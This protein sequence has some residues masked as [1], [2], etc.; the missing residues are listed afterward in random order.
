MVAER[1]IAKWHIDTVIETKKI[2]EQQIHVVVPSKRQASHGPVKPFDKSE[3]T[4]DEQTDCYTCPAG[5]RL[6]FGGVINPAI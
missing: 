5:H 2:D 6:P 3:F 1:R 4:Y